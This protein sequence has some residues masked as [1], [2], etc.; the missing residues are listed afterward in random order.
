MKTKKLRYFVHIYKWEPGEIREGFTAPGVWTGPFNRPFKTLTD[1][2][3]WINR[4]RQALV[5]AKAA[6]GHELYRVEFSKK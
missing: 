3:K 2:N 6:D 1:R 5:D 4:E